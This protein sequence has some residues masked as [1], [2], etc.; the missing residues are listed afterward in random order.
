MKTYILYLF[1]FSALGQVAQAQSDQKSSDE[2][3]Q[4]LLHQNLDF[5]I[6]GSFQD[7]QVLV[8]EISRLKD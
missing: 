8:R 6:D 1:L 2:N 5:L 3:C 7:E 4:Q